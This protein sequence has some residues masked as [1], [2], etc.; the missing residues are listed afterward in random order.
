MTLEEIVSFVHELDEKCPEGSDVFNT[1][2]MLL[3][4]LEVGADPDAVAEFTGLSL[5][6]IMTRAARLEKAEVWKDGKTYAEWADE[7]V[8]IIAFWLDVCIAED[9]LKRVAEEE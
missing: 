1:A 6:F 8:G 4:A 9:Y 5:E 2:I 3:A 7:E